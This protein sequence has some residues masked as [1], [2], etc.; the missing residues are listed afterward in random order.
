MWYK[1]ISHVLLSL[2]WQIYSCILLDLFF[3]TYCG[4]LLNRRCP[5]LVLVSRFMVLQ[6]NEHYH[7]CRF[8]SED[9][10]DTHIIS[11]IIL[12]Y[13]NLV[14]HFSQTWTFAHITNKFA[15]LALSLGI[16][17]IK[18]PWW[19][20]LV[21]ALIVFSFSYCLQRFIREMFCESLCVSSLSHFA[22]MQGD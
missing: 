16:C 22:L 12:R 2:H 14:C 10:R 9:R 11:G 8:L 1:F 4:T 17:W 18:L 15:I 20:F 7:K 13:T 5:C 3:W 21:M 19:I 6:R